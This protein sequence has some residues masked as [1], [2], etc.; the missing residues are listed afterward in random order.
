[1][2]PTFE[3][4]GRLTGGFTGT[5]GSSHR[6]LVDEQSLVDEAWVDRSRYH[7]M[8]TRTDV[9]HSRCIYWSHL[10]MNMAKL[11]FSSTVG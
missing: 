9:E 5:C 7:S 8:L 1:M 10:L 2:V 11:R 4:R 6:V 3:E